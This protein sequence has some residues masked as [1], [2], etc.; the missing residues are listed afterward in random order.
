MYRQIKY[1]ACRAQYY[2]FAAGVGI[3]VIDIAPPHQI[4]HQFKEASR[5]TPFSLTIVPF[6]KHM[7]NIGIE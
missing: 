1:V 4:K 5:L 6:T 3:V 2:M 7:F